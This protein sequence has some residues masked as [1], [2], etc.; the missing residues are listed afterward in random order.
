MKFAREYSDI[1]QYGAEIKDF[2]PFLCLSH[3][4]NIVP[5]GGKSKE[6]E[7]FLLYFYKNACFHPLF[8]WI[9]LLFWSFLSFVHSLFTKWRYN[10]NVL[11]SSNE[12]IHS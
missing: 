11:F 6:S 9:A 4:K 8:T 5:S 12:D 7:A 2:T 10:K 3:R 1:A